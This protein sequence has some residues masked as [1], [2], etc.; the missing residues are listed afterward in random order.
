MAAVISFDTID[1]SPSIQLLGPVVVKSA[2]GT[3][4]MTGTTSRLIVADLVLSGSRFSSDAALVELLWSDS[5]PPSSSAVRVAITRTRQHLQG[6][7]WA[8]V[9]V[10]HGYRL[11]GEGD[12]DTDRLGTL[13]RNLATSTQPHE[14]LAQCSAALA[15][16]HGRSLA[17]VRTTDGGSRL[18]DHLDSR[19][20]ALR[21][22]LV[23]AARS[24]E[25]LPEFLGEFRQ[26][27]SD[28]PLDESAVCAL[29]LA[30]GHT[31]Q[32][33]AGLRLLNSTRALLADVGVTP[34]A[35]LRACEAE[36][37]ALDA[38]R[39]SLRPSA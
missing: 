27:V 29:A 13:E 8:I 24:A 35:R 11:I 10:A 33:V 26:W 20:S 1:E 6:T 28:E 38:D 19:R 4:R 18:A 16:W 37:C 17:D 32:V 21:R 22:R 25:R 30:L 2:D 15:L 12:T 36:L 5:A 31:G 39:P 34:T 7:G 3:A 23:Y 9:R 14:A